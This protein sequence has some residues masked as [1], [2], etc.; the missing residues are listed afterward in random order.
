M[1]PLK[2]IHVFCIDCQGSARQVTNCTKENCP[3]WPFRTGKNSTRA[4]R[5]MSEE[6]RLAAAERFKKARENKKKESV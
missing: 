1:S 6:Q 5:V 3:L 2:G 4:K